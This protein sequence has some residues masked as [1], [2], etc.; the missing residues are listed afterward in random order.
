MISVPNYGADLTLSKFMPIWRVVEDFIDKQKILSA[1][2]CDFMLP[3]LSDLFETAKV[4]FRENKKTQ[5]VQWSSSKFS[6]KKQ[7]T[8]LFEDSFSSVIEQK[9]DDFLID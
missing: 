9:I 5:L 7:T 1:G 2:V 3:L 6:D 8:W 4:N